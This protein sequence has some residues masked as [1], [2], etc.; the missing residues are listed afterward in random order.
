MADR[1]HYFALGSNI[2]SKHYVPRMIDHWASVF[3]SV[4]LGPLFQTEPQQVD[5]QAGWSRLEDIEPM[6]VN[7]CFA[8]AAPEA[9]IDEN[10]CRSFAK[11]L[12]AALDRPL[13]LSNRRQV[14]RTIDIDY[15]VIDQKRLASEEQTDEYYSYLGLD[16]LLLHT[17][18]EL[19]IDGIIQRIGNYKRA[20]HIVKSDFKQTN[21]IQFLW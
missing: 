12:E 3:G 4:Y 6:F 16:Q 17:Q 11:I 5:L 13:D 8:V 7:A 14:S 18:P 10:W 2:L 9:W 1:F 20:V 19:S 15:L 21:R